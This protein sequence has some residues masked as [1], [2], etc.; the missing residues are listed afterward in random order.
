MNHNITC[1]HAKKQV[2]GYCKENK[3]KLWSTLLEYLNRKL[4]QIII[5]YIFYIQSFHNDRYLG[6]LVLPLCAR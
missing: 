2:S 3:V 4:G 1:G 6:I 5:I